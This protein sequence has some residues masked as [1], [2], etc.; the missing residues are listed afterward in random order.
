MAHIGAHPWR[1]RGVFPK[2]KNALRGFFTAQKEWSFFY[3]AVI[4]ASI[5][6]KAFIRNESEELIPSINLASFALSV[7]LLNSAIERTVD[8]VG[9]EYHTLARDA[10]D[11][12]A[13]ASMICH[14]S[15]MLTLIF[16]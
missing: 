7:E 6:G 5:I 8:R 9:L 2:I 10:K 12:S 14:I 11:I 15:V 1:V 3:C 13:A 4:D 16:G